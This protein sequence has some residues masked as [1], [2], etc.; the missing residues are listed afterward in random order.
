MSYIKV[1]NVKQVR[2]QYV[3]ARVEKVANIT[4]F[5]PEG[6]DGWNGSQVVCESCRKAL[7]CGSVDLAKTRVL[8][9]ERHLCGE[10]KKVAGAQ[11]VEVF[12]PAYNG[13][14]DFQIS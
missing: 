10:C 1:I 7:P 13:N 14:I 4:K 5:H 6:D 2:R 9:I 3:T 8:D 11:S 12:E